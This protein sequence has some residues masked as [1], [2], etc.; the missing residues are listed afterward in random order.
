M[1]FIKK[2]LRIL[3]YNVHSYILIN[4]RSRT[5]NLKILLYS[6]SWNLI[7]D[8]KFF[9]ILW[10]MDIKNENSLFNNNKIYYDVV[11]FN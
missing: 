9:K 6:F 1:I 3:G 2:F 8:H 4:I 10:Y 11:I 7:K 5:L